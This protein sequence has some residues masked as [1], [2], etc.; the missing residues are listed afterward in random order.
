MTVLR[1]KDYARYTQVVRQET[2][3]TVIILPVI[4][5][6]KNVVGIEPTKKRR[7]R[8]SKLETDMLRRLKDDR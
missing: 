5:I 4:R 1:F 6:P 2:P 3:A 8:R 7:A